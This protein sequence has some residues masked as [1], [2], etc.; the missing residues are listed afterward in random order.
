MLYCE[1]RTKAV[2]NIGGHTVI[3]PTRAA[4]V[5][6]EDRGVQDLIDR[7]LLVETDP[8]GED[9]AVPPGRGDKQ[10]PAAKADKEPSTVKELKAWLDEQGAQYSPSASKPELQG[11]YEALKAAALGEGGGSLES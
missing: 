1:N 6:P 5:N 4:W 8:P 10:A 11:L 9:A 7:E 2:I 3:A